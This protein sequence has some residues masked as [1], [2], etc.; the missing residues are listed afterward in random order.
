MPRL[1]PVSRQDLVRYLRQNGYDAPFAGERHEFMQEGDIRLI[2]P[3]PHRGDIGVDLLARIL[4]ETEI[5]RAEW[6][7][8]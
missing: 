2:L 5:S 7:R 8:Q 4:R 6:E 3:Y 1:G